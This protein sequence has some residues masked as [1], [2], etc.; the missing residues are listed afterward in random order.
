MPLITTKVSTEITKEKEISLKSEFGKAI[1]LIGKSENWLMVEFQD[2]CRLYFKGDD[3]PC[4]M[5][6]VDL[7]G[8]AS[9]SGYDA[10]T[11]KITEIVEAELG[12][13]K[14]RIYVKYSEIGH[15]GYSGFNF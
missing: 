8:K 3:A 6:E 5:I 13:P 4:A 7:F 11:Q 2:N 1:E 14:D 10:L 9:D 15:W 12:I